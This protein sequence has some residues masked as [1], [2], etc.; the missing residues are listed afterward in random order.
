MPKPTKEDAQI[1]IGLMSVFNAPAMMEARAF[2]GTLPDEVGPA[3]LFAKYPKGSIERQR[4]GSMMAFWDTVGILLKNG[5]LHEDLIFGS[6][7]G[8]P[9]WPKV[10]RFFEEAR[11]EG[12][13][14]EGDNLET[15][16]NMS[17]AWNAAREKKSAGR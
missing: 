9:P 12:N 8:D 14:D 5:L 17:V 4:F 3:E 2:W 15:A 13:P 11:K 7:L 6:F 1:L 16:Y 10:K